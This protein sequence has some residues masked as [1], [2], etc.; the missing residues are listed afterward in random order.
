[1]YKY[2]SRQHIIFQRSPHRVQRKSTIASQKSGFLEKKK[3]KSYDW[4][5]TELLAAFLTS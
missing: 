5:Y 4:P 1:M 3:D 2:G